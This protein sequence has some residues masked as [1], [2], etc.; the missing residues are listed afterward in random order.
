MEFNFA[1][2]WHLL[3]LAHLAIE[4]YQRVL[5]LGEQIQTE[6]QNKIPQPLTTNADP[7]DSSDVVKEDTHHA[8]QVGIRFVEDFSRE[9]AVAL[10]NIFALSGDLESA[11]E[12]TSK[13][14]VI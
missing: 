3:G 4:G 6:S 9:A 8:G 5:A 11:R 12:V 14:L 13:F 7:A 1:R 10:Q 2:V